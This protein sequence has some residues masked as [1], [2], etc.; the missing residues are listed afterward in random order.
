MNSKRNILFIILTS[1]IL[2]FGFNGA[3]NISYAQTCEVTAYSY[4]S[5]DT[6]AM[7]TPVHVGECASRSTDIA[8]GTTVYING[9]AYVVEDRMNPNAE[10][11]F[12]IFVSS[13]D[14]AYQF[15]R[16]WLDVH[17]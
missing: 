14:E 2:I 10:A 5:G 8:L 6:T 7:G 4:E 15:G 9:V 13:T 1:I 12:D 16:Q 3:S 11:E 17:F